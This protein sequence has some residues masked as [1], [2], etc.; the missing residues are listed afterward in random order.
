MITKLTDQRKKIIDNVQQDK[1][2]SCWQEFALTP[3][4]Y[5][6]AFEKDKFVEVKL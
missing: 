1:M 3:T 6:E 2:M 4:I 5:E